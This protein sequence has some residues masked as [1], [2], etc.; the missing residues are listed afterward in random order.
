[1]KVKKLMVAAGLV[2]ATLAPA[3]PLTGHATAAPHEQGADT[4]A[5]GTIET[6]SLTNAAGTRE[7]QIYTPRN[8]AAGRPLLVW[9]HGAVRVDNGDKRE[10]QRDSTLLREADRRGY[11]VVAPM[12]SYAAEA[13]GTWQIFQPANALRGQGETSIIADI[14]TTATAELRSD[15]RRVSIVGHS[16]GGGMT[17]NVSATYPELFSAV[18]IVAGFPYAFDPSGVAIRQSRGGRS[19]PT[20]VVHGDRDSVAIPALGEALCL[21]NRQ[22]NGLGAAGPRSVDAVSPI[23]RDRYRTTIRTY[24]AGR[25]VVQCAVVHGAEHHTGLGRL[26]VDGP[27]LDRR[28]IDFLL[29]AH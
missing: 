11:A 20:F 12:Q 16:A 3:G 13:R 4:L 28:M 17:G 27:A 25:D 26:T 8:F 15:R 6:H 21:A 7:Y 5:R 14:V 23:G 19:L 18:G 1:M 24:G 2:L 9:L 22:A 29:A 10:L